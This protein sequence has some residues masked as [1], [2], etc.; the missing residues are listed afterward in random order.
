MRN[1]HAAAW[2]GLIINGIVL[3]FAL[4]YINEEALYYYDS[5]YGYLE[6][7]SASRM[8]GI[9]QVFSLL[10]VGGFVMSLVGVIMLFMG[11]PVGGIIGAIGAAIY[12]P[13]GMICMFGCIQ[14]RS[15]MHMKAYESPYA[16]GTPSGGA[17]SSGPGRQQAVSNRMDAAAVKTLSGDYSQTGEAA[18]AYSAQPAHRS[19]A[20]PGTPL[21][22]YK[23]ADQSFWGWILI[24][25]VIVGV[26]ILYSM[27]GRIPGTLFV[28]LAA[29]RTAA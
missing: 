22:A 3:F 27:T 8:D 10:F 9:T 18:A 14:S 23:F 12:V 24:V 15:R 7:L 6:S 13:I 21:V 2:I 20:T 19:A 28:P 17:V 5:G 4:L 1:V 25:I 11:K 29:A 26:A 16:A